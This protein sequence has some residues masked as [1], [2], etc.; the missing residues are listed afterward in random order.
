[1]KAPPTNIDIKEAIRRLIA[2]AAM[3]EGH[4]DSQ[5]FRFDICSSCAKDNPIVFLKQKE[6][7]RSLCQKCADDYR[8]TS[9]LV[10]NPSSYET[11]IQQA[12]VKYPCLKA[13]ACKE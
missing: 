2:Y 5:E 9:S 12:K 8:K 10:F 7:R 1:M 6:S 4:P 11:T 13:G 3:L